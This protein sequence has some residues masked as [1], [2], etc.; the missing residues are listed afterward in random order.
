MLGKKPINSDSEANL[1]LVVLLCV[2]VAKLSGTSTSISRLAAC[3]EAKA[4]QKK[5]KRINNQTDN[6]FEPAVLGNFNAFEPAVLWLTKANPV[7]M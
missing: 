4:C 1:F 3:I 7:D 6:A 2:L 5:K